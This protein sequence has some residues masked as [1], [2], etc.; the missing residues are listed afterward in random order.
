MV[1]ALLI[2][3]AVFVTLFV[4]W[5]PKAKDPLVRPSLMKVK[6]LA[7]MNITAF[8]IGFALFTTIQTIAGLAAF[9]FQ[10]DTIQIGLLL[11][12][13]SAVTLVL[14]PTVGFLV[15]RIGPKW[16]LTFGMTIAIVGFMMLY[17]NHSTKLDVML[18]ATILG[19]GQAFA[20]VSSIN[21][22]IVST[23]MLETGISTAVN[24]IIRTAGS[25]VGPAIAAVIIS[26]N[27]HFDPVVGQAVP[28][29]IAYRTIFLMASIV[30]A[31]GV[32]LSLFV[33]N[34]KSTPQAYGERGATGPKAP[35][36]AK[37]AEA[38]LRH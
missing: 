26:Q 10:L 1:V 5:L 28:G 19:A 11:L 21:I 25:V 6:N 2:A 14:G 35:V 32:F 34:Q 30:M 18:G 33:Q 20:M 13:T 37:P 17:F 29:D 9:N 4:L 38:D 23:P 15:R 36:M 7:L 24:M 27:S 3:S 16:P 31:L 12:P 8:I 22:V